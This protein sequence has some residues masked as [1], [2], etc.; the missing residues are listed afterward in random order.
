M[1]KVVRD[2]SPAELDDM[3]D[4]K[5]IAMGI[6][7]SLAKEFLKNPHC[8]PQ[9]STLLVGELE[10]MKNVADRENFVK[11]AAVAP[12]YMVARYMRERA[13]MMANYHLNVSAAVR[14]VQVGGTPFLQRKDGII[15]GPFP[16]DY[17]VWTA[18]LWRKEK[19]ISESIERLPGVTG[20]EL[21]IQGAV[22]PVARKALESRGWKVDD[23]V[24]DK[25][26]KK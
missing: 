9:E 1:R 4:K 3:N 13:Q 20:K 5:L 18:T 11:V 23:N 15:I 8:D 7:D 22:D 2:K 16:L 25:L 21:W 14:I 6:S 24:G 26:I 19:V 10:S 12:E 17:V